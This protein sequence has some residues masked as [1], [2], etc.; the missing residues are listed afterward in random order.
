[1]WGPI[2][3]YCPYC[4][5]SFNAW[6]GNGAVN[7]VHQHWR[8]GCELDPVGQKFREMRARFEADQVRWKAESI[9]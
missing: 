6:T 2:S 9:R 8:D 5:E 4:F 7:K 1:M 3:V